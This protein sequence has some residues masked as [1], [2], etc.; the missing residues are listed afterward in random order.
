MSSLVFGVERD[1]RFS[2]MVSERYNAGLDAVQKFLAGELRIIAQ[3]TD[4]KYTISIVDYPTNGEGL[5]IVQRNDIMDK[6]IPGGYWMDWW[7]PD[8]GVT[9]K[10]YNKMLESERASL[11][12]K[13][14]LEKWTDG[15][16]ALDFADFYH[17]EEYDKWFWEGGGAEERMFGIDK[18][19]EYWKQRLKLGTKDNGKGFWYIN[20]RLYDVSSDWM[21]GGT[22]DH[23]GFLAIIDKETHPELQ[24]FLGLTDAEVEALQRAY[25]DG[26]FGDA[27]IATVRKIYDSGAIRLRYFDF[28]EPVIGIQC[29]SPNQRLQEV[30]D[31]LFATGIY[32][33]PNTRVVIETSDETLVD[34]TTLENLLEGNIRAAGLTPLGCKVLASGHTD[35]LEEH[36]IETV[37]EGS[38][39]FSEKEQKWYG[40]S[41]RAIHGF[42]IGDEVEKGDVMTSSGWTPEYLKE[43]PEED[44]SLPVGFKAKTLDDAK[45]MAESFAEAVSSL[46][47][48]KQLTVKSELVLCG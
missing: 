43:H 47:P 38:I 44:K 8:H 25:S 13:L 42:G 16:F 23:V 48:Q 39:G 45:K 17:P 20:G 24:Q 33:E 29:A 2:P 21:E 34:D 35:F 46:K 40:W 26:T 18:S 32:A 19:N 22:N 36:G 3:E 10:Q 1:P 5:Q 31:A 30:I 41:H 6:P 28:D 11:E 15:Q 37:G 12:C 27:A 7:E 4:G 9:E 14:Q